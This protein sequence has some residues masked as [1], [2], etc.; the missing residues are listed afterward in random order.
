[1]FWG[2]ACCTSGTAFHEPCGFSCVLMAW[3]CNTL[4]TDCKCVCCSVFQCVQ[5]IACSVQLVD[6]FCSPKLQ[7]PYRA[8]ARFLFAALEHSQRVS[9]RWH[10]P[11]VVV[12]WGTSTCELCC[13][14]NCFRRLWATNMIVKSALIWAGV[15]LDELQRNLPTQL[16]LTPWFVT[17]HD[18]APSC[19]SLS[20]FQGFNFS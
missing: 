16:F 18:C 5:K 19:T 17:A 20:G 4:G 3:I 1:M 10:L 13:L 15:G 12:C 14:L 7:G 8:W 2:V 11:T 9:F 6:V